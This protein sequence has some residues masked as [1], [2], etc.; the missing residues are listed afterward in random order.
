MPTT[1]FIL[2][3]L[4]ACIAIAGCAGQK[5]T[6]DQN[7]S[8]TPKSS[9]PDARV[10]KSKDGTFDGEIIGTAAPDSKF[11][12]L[13]IGMIMSEVTGLMGAPDNLM[14]HETGKRWIPFYFGPDAKRIEVLYKGEGCLTYT[15][16][17]RFGGGGDT[18]IRIAVDS[19]GTCFKS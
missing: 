15:G 9:N 19:T 2:T 4:L 17:N 13:Q 1:K 6:A 11:A 14:K 8:A 16:G 18:L 5:T 12:K 7:A 3:S 10:V